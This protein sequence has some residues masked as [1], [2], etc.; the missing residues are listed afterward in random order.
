MH[1]SPKY[2]LSTEV[3]GITIGE[4]VLVKRK[5]AEFISELRYK[6]MD[7]VNGQFYI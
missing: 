3:S 7:Q 4:R 1:R 2:Y 6:G 5:T